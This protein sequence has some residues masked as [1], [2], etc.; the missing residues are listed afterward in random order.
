[1][2][3][4]STS[5][6]EI[7][8]DTPKTDENSPTEVIDSKKPSDILG[9]ITEVAKNGDP[10]YAWSH[11]KPILKERIEGVLTTLQE[12]TPEVPA[13]R[14]VEPFVFEELK[15]KILSNLDSFNR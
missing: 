1:M 13:V 12:T 2:D 11:L 4:I 6:C 10:K 8:L 9:T 15:S 14:N 7:F 3:I 5:Y